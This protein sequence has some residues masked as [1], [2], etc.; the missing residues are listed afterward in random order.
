MIGNERCPL[1][2][3]PALAE[4]A[5][6]FEE[7]GA[8]AFVLDAGSRWA[9]ITDELRLSTD[10]RGALSDVPLGARFGSTESLETILAWRYG[11]WTVDGV[12]QAVAAMGPWVLA[13]MPGGRDALREALDPRLRDLV[14]NLSLSDRSTA[15]AF[16]TPFVM[17]GL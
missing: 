2:R 7:T 15:F 10:G 14:D 8:W 16:T 6:A 9:Y 11:G 5:S 1:P 17:Q 12:R 4:V 3:D 13:D